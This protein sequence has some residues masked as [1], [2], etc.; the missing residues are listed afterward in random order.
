MIP[1]II[2]QTHENK[3]NDLLPFQKDIT[4]T[5]K[6]LNP[7]WEY[8]YVDAE[9]REKD[10]Q[11]YSDVIYECYKK[12]SKIN[13][14]DFWRIINLY[15]NGGIYADMDSVCLIP[16]NDI[17]D[18]FYKGEDMI[19][20]SEGGNLILG[21]T[22]P[23]TINLSN[24][25]SVKNSKILKNIL[26]EVEE[27]CKDLIKTEKIFKVAMWPGMPV[28]ES[29]SDITKKNKNN[30]LFKDEYCY[31]SKIFKEKFDGNYEVVYNNESI[32]Y[33][34]LVTLKQWRILSK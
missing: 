20:T 4:N 5:W 32:N 6:N 25:G 29:F 26:D 16:L 17:I 10:V 27:K 24:F 7:D 14:A 18:N 9:Q 33:Q 15:K 21:P 30:I 28:Y 2:W 11:E 34:K 31:H 23:G 8:R 19:C 12:A 13:K 1:K 22:W 3:Y